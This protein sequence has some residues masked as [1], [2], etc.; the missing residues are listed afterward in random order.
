MKLFNIVKKEEPF[1]RAAQAFA[2]AAVGLCLLAGDEGDPKEF[3]RP[4]L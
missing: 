4:V 1:H 3:A 2:L